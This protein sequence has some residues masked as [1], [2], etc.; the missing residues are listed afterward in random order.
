MAEQTINVFQAELSRS[1]SSLPQMLVALDA[2]ASSPRQVVIAGK[3]NAADT[4]AI[5]R[6]V[7]GRFQPNAVLILADGGSGQA[8]FT[9]KVEF[10]KDV[11]PID[12]KATAYICQNFVCQL[13]TNDLAVISRLLDAGKSSQ[14]NNRAK[15]DAGKH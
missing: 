8:F 11:H 2:A 1:P 14:N 15:Q 9:Q 6:E 7:N 13:P 3:P 10:F 12:N 5:L 4:S